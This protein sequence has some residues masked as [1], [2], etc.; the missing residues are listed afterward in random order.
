MESAIT[1][2]NTIRTV[3]NTGKQN[4]HTGIV[5]LMRSNKNDNHN[6]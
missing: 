5:C 3:E 2:G 6:I 1:E 4:L